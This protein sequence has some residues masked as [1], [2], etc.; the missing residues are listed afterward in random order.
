MYFRRPDRSLLKVDFAAV[1]SLLHFVQDDD[2]KPEAGGILMGRL[3]RGSNN[4][5]VDE[6]TEPLPGDVRTRFTFE[7]AAK[8][9]QSVLD[10]HWS[11][12]RG[13]CGYLGEWHTHAE[14]F[15]SPSSVD[16]RDWRRRLRSD[17]FD[18]GQLFFVIVGTEDI[19]VWQGTR[20]C[21]ARAAVVEAATC[22]FGPP[23]GGTPM[24]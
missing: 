10:A 19:G 4:I 20:G 7:R 1:Q 17:E 23:G 11:E 3:L 12:S 9:H 8:Q 21:T 24:V 14:P 6:I 18:I 22:W 16:L 2:V 15:P 13:T 5:V